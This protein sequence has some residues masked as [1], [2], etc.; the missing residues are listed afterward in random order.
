MCC[1]LGLILHC[2]FLVSVHLFYVSFLHHCFN[3]FFLSSFKLH[4]SVNFEL[5]VRGCLQ[6]SVENIVKEKMPKK[7]GRWWFSWRSRNSDSKSVSTHLSPAFLKYTF[8]LRVSEKGK[9]DRQRLEA[10]FVPSLST[11]NLCP[12]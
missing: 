12:P 2:G 7:G 3:F 8:Q 9:D 6:A 10:I 5:Y 1:L 11:F 4:L